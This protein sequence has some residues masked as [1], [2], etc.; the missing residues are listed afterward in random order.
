MKKIWALI[1]PLNKNTVHYEI[2]S[3]IIMF[4][5]FSDYFDKIKINELNRNFFI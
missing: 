3:I 2:V 5:F 1:N 4:L